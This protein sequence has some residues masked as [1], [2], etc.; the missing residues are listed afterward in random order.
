MSS[1]EGSPQLTPQ[2]AD[3]SGRRTEPRVEASYLV[4]FR[5]IDD[6]VESYTRNISRGGLF[7]ATK[8]FLPIGSIV[9]LNVELPDDK[10]PASVLARVAYVLGVEAAEARKSNAGMGMEFLH[11]DHEVGRRIAEQLV[12]GLDPQPSDEPITA[13]VLVVDDSPMYLERAASLA[14]SLGHR[15]RTAKNGLEAIGL[16]MK[17]PADIVLCD[18]QMPMMDGWQFLRI[19]RSRPTLART[20]VIF[21]TTLTGEPERLRGYQLGVDDYLGKP[22]DD[23]ELAA[24]IGR[25]LLRSKHRPSSSADRGAL[26]GDLSLVSLPSVLSFIEAERRTG[27]L[28]VISEPHIATLHIQAG[29]VHRVDLST[30]VGLAGVER[31][32]HVLDWTHGRFEFGPSDADVDDELKLPTSYVLMEHA[33]RRDESGRD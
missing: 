11:A 27:A 3:A 15:V 29:A 19:V 1:D 31:L 30:D 25:V 5:S 12:R 24:R 26:S 21:L 10:P 6:M 20:P 18:V 8:R 9:R 14:R 17:E 13:D 28:L 2:A 4:R 7:I 33:R 23:E 22:F 16:L 32:F